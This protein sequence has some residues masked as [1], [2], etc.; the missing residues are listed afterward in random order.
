M[1]VSLSLVG[2]RGGGLGLGLGL[3]LDLVRLAPGLLPTA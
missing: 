1:R 3:I 2:K